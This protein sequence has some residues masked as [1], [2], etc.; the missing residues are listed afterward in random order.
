[1]YR[2]LYYILLLLCFSGVSL[3]G[4]N[5]MPIGKWKAWTSM[6]S[7]KMSTWRQGTFFTITK[8]GLFSFSESTGE[9]RT[10]TTVDGLSGLNTSSI[11][12]DE[13]HDKVIIGYEDGT[14]NYFTTPD[15]ISVVSDIRRSQLFG[16]KRIN[17]IVSFGNFIFISN[18]IF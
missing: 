18:A 6:N 1:M 16:N 5:N 13:L 14:L 3:K 11:F 8:G 7:P 15:A 10:F 2:R 17:D 4:Q 9:I 12:Y